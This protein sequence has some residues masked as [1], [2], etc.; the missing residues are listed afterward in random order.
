VFKKLITAGAGAIA[1]VIATLPVQGQFGCG[2]GGIGAGTCG[3]CSTGPGLLLTGLAP[4]WGPWAWCGNSAWQ[5]LYGSGMML[6]NYMPWS[7]W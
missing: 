1:A 3:I 5:W 6:P 7:W 2:F 4:F